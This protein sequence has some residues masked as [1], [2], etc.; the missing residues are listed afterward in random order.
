M[1]VCTTGPHVELIKDPDG[2]YSQLLRLQEVNTKREGSHGDDSSRL[3]SASDTA[4]SA[5]QHSSIKPSFGR[6]MS[7][8]SPQGGSRRNSQTFSLHEHETEGVDDA[9]SGKNVIRRLLYLHKPEIPILLLGCTAAAANGAILPVFGM[10]LSSAINT[11][12]EPPQQL[13][14]DSVFWA[15]MYVMLGVISIFVIPLQYALFNMAGGKLIERIRAVSFSRVVYQ[16]IG[17]FDD[18]L[19]SSGA[20]GSRLSGDAASV[21]SIAGDV[22]SLI[23]Q[24]ISTAVVG[25]VI[26]MISNWKLACIVLSFLPCVIAQSYAQTRLMRGF[27]ADAKEMYEQASTIATDAIGN[28]RTVASFCA[29]EKIIENYRKKCEGPVRQGVRQ[30]AISGVGYGFSFALLFCFYAISFYV[31][32]RFV[33]NGTAEVGQVFRV[34]FALTMM[35]VGVS[36]S[37]SLARDFAKV[38]NAAAS[39]F[40]IIDRKSKIDASHEVGTTLEAVEGNIELQ[41]VSF[42]Y[43]AR[44][45]VQIFRDLCLRIPSG[46][47]LVVCC[48]LLRLSGKAEVGNLR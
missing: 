7:R 9:K 3:Q 21:K 35:A 47:I 32:A 22:L 37:S 8:Y 2:A 4:N 20:I 1:H 14:K 31:G 6:S 40:K 39:I 38:Q 19:N 29:E 15:E 25:I 36:Q 13:R 28:I 46:K 24:S 43:P 44:T 23:V 11:F 10:L 48:R 30:G 34:F 41:H 16:E 5:S 42:K 26:A 17:W 18:P 45:D 27:G 12:Y 33:H